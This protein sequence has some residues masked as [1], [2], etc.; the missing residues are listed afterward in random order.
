MSAERAFAH[1]RGQGV[2]WWALRTFPGLRGVFVFLRGIWHSLCERLAEW[3]LTLWLLNWGIVLAYGGAVDAPVVKVLEPWAT[4][5]SWA[6]FCL[7]GGGGRLAL[8]IV[9]GGWRKSPHFRVLAALGTIPLWAAF[10]YG[11]HQSGSIASAAGA[12]YACIFSELVSMYRATREAGW[13][14]GRAAHQGNR[15]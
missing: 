15:G 14:D 12:Y 8:L 2:V 4:I 9:N 11:F 1:A 6:L 10:A 5:E 13:N 3:L 7:L